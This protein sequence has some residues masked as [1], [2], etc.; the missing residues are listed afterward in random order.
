MKCY[1][2]LYKPHCLFWNIKDFEP[3]VRKDYGKWENT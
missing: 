1:D 2:Y 3:N